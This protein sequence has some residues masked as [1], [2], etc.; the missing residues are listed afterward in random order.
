MARKKFVAGNWKMNTTRVEA[1]N[2]GSSL[3]T[4]L[5]DNCPVDV[6]IFPPFVWIPAVQDVV[7]GS[8]VKLGAQNA[9]HQSKGAYT[10]E[11]SASMLRELGCEYVIIGHSERRYGIGE[12][13]AL[14]NEKVHTALD[15][16]LRV[17]LCVGE[18]LTERERNLQGRVLQRQVFAGCAGLSN[19]QLHRLV[20]AY[21]PVWA[22]GTGRVATPDQAQSAHRDI[23][24]RLSQLFGEPIAQGLRILYGGSVTADN[25]SDLLAQPDVD[26]VLVGGASLN[27]ESFLNI[28]R[29]AV[30][31][32]HTAAPS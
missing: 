21:E 1:R 31:A 28:V 18:T 13:D 9:H 3:A 16:E 25:A 32:Q 29:A 19:G 4:A 17:I 6:A 8:C 22:I 24:L 15:A 26:G 12:S 30:A 11:I 14:I 2:L 27:P 20:I 7:S 10:G 5:G 23:R